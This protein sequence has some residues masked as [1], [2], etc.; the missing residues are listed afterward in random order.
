LTRLTNVDICDI[1]LKLAQYNQ[2]LLYKT[3]RTLLGIACHANSKDEHEIENQIQSCSIHVIPINAGQGI[4]N[5]FSKTVAAILKFLG[6]KAIVADQPD[7]SGIATAYEEKA[8]AIMMADD[9]RFVGINLKNQFLIDNSTATGRVFVSALDLMAKGIKN[10]KVLVLGC[11]PVGEVAA[12]TL[13]MFNARVSL[14]DIEL[15]AA[16]SLKKK[17][18]K[19]P[20]SDRIFIEQ[21]LSTAL[22]NNCYIVEATPVAGTISDKVIRDQMIVA[23][24]GVP[25]G[26]STN[27]CRILKNRLIHDKLEL[28]VA[29]MAIS[30]FS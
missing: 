4:I 16:R 10:R 15:S 2:E 1:P 3:G 19:Y 18:L 22:L 14:F 6:F 13:L 8:D 26:I 12:Q 25:L 21:S 20:G 17:L 7:T 28:G 27:G 11:G 30:M 5:D 24:P 23:A 9:H 29:A